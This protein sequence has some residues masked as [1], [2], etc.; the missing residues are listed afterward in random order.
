MPRVRETVFAAAVGSLTLPLAA[1]PQGVEVSGT[2][3]DAPHIIPLEGEAGTYFSGSFQGAGAVLTLGGTDAPTLRQLAKGTGGAERVH[4]VTTAPGSQL[5]ISGPKGAQYDL[6]LTVPERLADQAAPR[7]A[8]MSPRLREAMVALA[9]GE[10]ATQV[11]AD[12][13]ADGTPLVEEGTSDSQWL[14]FLYFGAQHNVRLLGGPSSDHDWLSRLGDSAI[15][16]RSYQVPSDTRL[17]YRL[18][19]DVPQIAGDWRE[20]R[21]AILASA[22]ADPENRSPWPATA[23]D[24]WQQW[25]TVSLPDAPQQPGY[26][27][28]QGRHPDLET[29]VFASTKLGNSRRLDLYRSPQFDPRDPEA[30]LLLMFDGPRAVE[31][32]EIPQMLDALTTSGRLPSVA[33]VFIDPIDFAH[34]SEELPGNARF[35]AFLAEEVLPH[36][37]A[38]FGLKHHRART[39]LAG[40]SYGGIGATHAALDRPESFGAVISLSGSYWWSPSGGQ[41][42]RDGLTYMS[43]R[44][45]REGVPQGLRSYI[46]A[47][48]FE[49]DPTGAHDIRETS[50]QVHA[51]LR[52]LGAQSHWRLYSGGH[53][54]FVWRGAFADGLLHLFARQ[55]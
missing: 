53:D 22:A 50:R 23:P 33:A 42:P 52:A 16:Y 27:Q 43:E 14:T 10:D 18:A 31:E 21:I 55:E 17:S 40:A 41:G 9:E 44:L 47:G 15:W 5:Q 35:S 4:F 37:L 48:A 6:Q 39:V 29:E 8:L 28:A 1:F 49:V 32:W 20:K 19:P 34:R 12:L 36:A 2:L 24:A 3:R 54:G 45:I 26:E 13:A 7:D 38:Y 51:T 25:S 11:W 46:A 30:I